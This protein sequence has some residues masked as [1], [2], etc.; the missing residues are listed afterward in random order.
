MIRFRGWADN[1][2]RESLGTRSIREAFLI[3]VVSAAA[4]YLVLWVEALPGGP[5]LCLYDQ[6]DSK[7]FPYPYDRH[8][9][10]KYVTNEAARSPPTLCVKALKTNGAATKTATLMRIYERKFV[11]AE[12]LLY[13]G[14]RQLGNLARLRAAL[15]KLLDGQPI[16]VVTLGGS[17]MAGGDIYFPRKASDSFVGQLFTWL[18]KTF[19][20]AQHKFHNGCLPATGSTFI[21]IC[22]DEHVVHKDVDLILLEFDIN[23]ASPDGKWP[24]QAYMDNRWRRGLEVLF[25]RLLKYPNSPALLYFHMWMPGFQHNSFW[26]TT[27]EDETEILVAYYQLQSLSFRNAIFRPFQANKPGFQDL[28]ISCSYVHPTYLGHRYMADIIIAFLQDELARL[29]VEPVLPQEAAAA[30]EEL[31]PPMLPG[32][33]E[34]SSICLEERNL[35]SAVVRSKG[36]SWEDEPTSYGAH[37]YGF[38][39]RHPGAIIVFKVDT[40]NPHAGAEQRNWPWPVPEGVTVAVGIVKSYAHMGKGMI[41][42]SRGC[43]CMNGSVSFDAT[44]PYRI[45]VRKWVY[46]GVSESKTC[47]IQ[48]TNVPETSSGGHKL[49][50]NA[51]AV[52]P[53]NAAEGYAFSLSV[54]KPHEQDLPLNYD[55]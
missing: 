45:S 29:L 4:V 51:L 50:I 40:R 8:H 53:F 34:H 23:D 20:H 43:T 11:L 15:Q 25:R 36:W 19:P 12:D 35:R 1:I 38:I 44:W 54:W 18:A 52:L 28:D 31:P 7:A 2:K 32:N 16:T 27:I 14:R 46:V 22:L 48:V 42:C 24:N 5:S 17:I 55:V 33:H 49:K 9:W 13:A 21:S 6:D 47:F 39:S 10:F 3:L 37:R 41:R 26:N 30:A